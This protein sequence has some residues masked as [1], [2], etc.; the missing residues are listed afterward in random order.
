ML[1]KGFEVL[2][3]EEFAQGNYRMPLA[4][5][6]G[7]GTINVVAQNVGIRG[8]PEDILSTLRGLVETGNFIE[9]VEVDSMRITG[10]E[11]TPRGEERFTTYGFA[12]AAGGVGQRFYSKYYADSDPNPGTILKIV[13]QTLASLPFSIPALRRLPGSLQLSEYAE[14]IFEPCEATVSVDGM[15]L[16]HSS[17][18]G[19]HIGSMSLNIGGVFR[20]FT[21]ADQQGLMHCLVGAPSPFTIA[22]NIH[23]LHLGREI[24]GQDVLDRPCRSLEV[25]ATGEELLA[26]VIDGEYYENI[27]SIRFEPGPRVRIPKVVTD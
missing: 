20:L 23:N 18:T 4:V 26:P 9:E 15:M 5:P 22:R 19:I 16:P 13:A 6:T 21:K 24:R 3:E 12:A 7:G 1:K 17:Y 11:R 2:E 14:Q 8:K 10:T 25:K 27:S